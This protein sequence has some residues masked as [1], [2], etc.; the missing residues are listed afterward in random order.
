MFCVNVTRG[1]C[2]A[3]SSIVRMA[4]RDNAVD[5]IALIANGDDC[6]LVV[7]VFAAVTTICS[8]D[9]TIIVSESEMVLP[10]SMRMAR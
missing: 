9:A 4:K 6:T 3:A 2:A 1:V 7:P 8:S 10:E 5:E